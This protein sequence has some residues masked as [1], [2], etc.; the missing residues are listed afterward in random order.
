[1]RRPAPAITRLH[2]SLGHLGSRLEQHIREFSHQ[3]KVMLKTHREQLITRQL[4]Q[5]RLSRTVL[6]IHATACSLS[7]L[8]KS[9]RDG[10]NG[11]ALQD[12]TKTVEHLCD[13]ADEQITIQLR[14]LRHNTD[15]TM[16]GAAR[17]AM[18]QMDSMPHSDYVIP[19]STPDE[20]ALGTG[21]EPDQTHIQQFG[22]GSLIDRLDLGA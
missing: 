14:G 10:T 2:P 1:M 18:K 13:L 17:V 11:E 5:E 15:R 6:W 4:L 20:S 12:E 7:R 16:A 8:D 19:E 22:S 9:I 3:I 21:R